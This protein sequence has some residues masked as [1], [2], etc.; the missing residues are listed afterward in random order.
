VD[1]EQRT[2]AP[3]AEMQPLLN[4]DSHLDA[5][6]SKVNRWWRVR[7]WLRLLAT[8]RRFLLKFAAYGFLLSA[9][10]AFLIPRKYD[11]T[12]LLMPP[13][14]QSSSGLAMLASM[15]GSS[16]AG[17]LAGLAGDLLG[18]KSSGALFVGML[19]SRTVEDALIQ[20]FDLRRV[21][22]RRYWLDARKELED[23]TNIY[24][25][26]KSGIIAVTVRDGN[27]ERAQALA[28]AYVE[29][30]DKAVANLSTSSARREREFLEE[31][32]K[33]VKQ[34]LEH[35]EKDFSQFAS[36]NTAIDIPAQG[37]A[38]VEAASRLQGEMIAA[39]AEVHGLSQIYSPNNVRVRS[40]QARVQELRRQLNEIGGGGQQPGD[41][42]NAAASTESLYPSIRKLPL[43]G[44]TYADL[45]RQT[46]IQQTV[47]E[48]LTE[49]YELAKVQEAKEIPTVR[50]LD[51][52]DLP[53]KKAFPHRGPIILIGTILAFFYA[54]LWVLATKHWSEID[55]ADPAKAF[56]VEVVQGISCHFKNLQRS[57][58]RRIFQNSRPAEVVTQDSHE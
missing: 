31:R 11:S 56:I 21:Y 18:A 28:R 34:D 13:D 40:A 42:H 5:E 33:A 32:L 4:A 8:E 27:P 2:L 46:K 15:G 43:L 48:T 17:T 12:T 41:A 24:E 47:F 39:E 53:E 25:D 51:S 58:Q 45:F 3:A 57:A 20:R 26:R 14:N 29:E 16:G 9:A 6:L 7:T 49:E 54:V 55:S 23:R 37:K 36:E 44:M 22:S 19:R 1:A 52:A 38:M 50:V 35:A 10:V 30:L